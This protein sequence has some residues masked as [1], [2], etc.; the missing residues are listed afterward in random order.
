MPTRRTSL[1][2]RD[3]I[4]SAAGAGAAFALAGGAPKNIRSSALGNADT[5]APSERLT[6][7][8]IGIG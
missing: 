5:A 3:F 6:L 7:G 4:K 1:T 8:F 2:R